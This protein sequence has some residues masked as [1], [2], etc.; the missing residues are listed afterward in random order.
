M[1]VSCWI[2]PNTPPNTNGWIAKMMG[3]LEKVAPLKNMAILVS[4]LIFGGVIASKMGVSPFL[5]IK[6]W[7]FRV[8][9]VGITENPERSLHIFH[10]SKI[11]PGKKT[12]YGLHKSKTM[13]C[14]WSI[15]YHL[16][17]L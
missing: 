12:H 9:T 16:V 17:K 7:W 10:T 13:R 11:N 3:W 15:P 2:T 8:P 5:P 14:K 1:V 6:T 4:M